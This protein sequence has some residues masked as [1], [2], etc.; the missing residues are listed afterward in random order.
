M[1][2]EQ[3]NK[4][5]E[6]SEIEAKTWC[7]TYA[8][9]SLKA[10]RDNQT[11]QVGFDLPGPSI[12]LGTQDDPLIAHLADSIKCCR[13]PI[14]ADFPGRGRGMLAWNLMALG[15]DLETIACVANDAEGMNEAVGTLFQ[16][17]VGLD[18]LTPLVLPAANSV[19]PAKTRVDPPA[20]TAAWQTNLPD[21]VAAIAVGNDGGLLAASANTTVWNI[22]VTANGKAAM[23]PSAAKLDAAKPA[24]DV[25][26]LP[27]DKLCADLKVKQVLAGNGLTAVAYWGGRLQ[28]I[29]TDG[30]LKAQQQ[31]PQD[32]TA[33]AWD[34]DT[35]VVGLAD[36][37]LLGLNAQ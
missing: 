27:K 15:H 18:D 12:L 36:G 33:L 20:A 10:G 34:K 22:A 23:T 35:L 4:P 28:I 9:G 26:G 1:T 31:L 30:T 14:T 24:T 6:L 17:A 25:T 8:A 2:A 29:A 11:I 7:G 3:A 21:R 13:T 32:I 5:R 37:C 16:L 19:L